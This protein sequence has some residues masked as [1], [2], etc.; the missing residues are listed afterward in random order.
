LQELRNP[1][2]F[3]PNK[4]PEMNAEMFSSKCVL[5]VAAAV[6]FGFVASPVRAAVLLQNATATLSQ[7]GFGV[8]FAIDGT[9]DASG[10]AVNNGTAVPYVDQV[11]VFETVT[12]LNAPSVTIDMLHRFSTSHLV[13]KFRWSVTTD[14][15]SL[16]ADG[17]LTGGNV[18]AN[19]T[20]L[21]P[22]SVL[23]PTGMTNTISNNIILTG[24][25]FQVLMATNDY[26]VAYDLPFGEITGFRLEVF[27]DPTLPQSP[28][29]TPGM[30]HAQGNFVLSEV[31]VTAVPEPS[32]LLLAGMGLLLVTRRRREA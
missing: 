20:E 24:G 25:T 26:Q 4:K 16:F 6:G 32:A 31:V 7:S 21:V 23:L 22:T 14:D 11:A 18:T 10:W 15:R 8:G 27:T 29:S 9:V 12:N 13:G 17:L 19:W 3:T 2:T 5:S 28:F 1:F 30:G